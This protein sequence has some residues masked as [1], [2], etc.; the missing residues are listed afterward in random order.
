MIK[1]QGG[2]IESGYSEKDIKRLSIS[3][4][5]MNKSE[6]YLDGR[7]LVLKRDH[8]SK[9]SVAHKASGSQNF[10]FKV[11]DTEYD[12]DFLAYTATEAKQ[13]MVKRLRKTGDLI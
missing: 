12:K 9:G 7:F 8:P 5:R 13:W 4:L 10:A 2:I 1:I 3:K 11:H 6:E